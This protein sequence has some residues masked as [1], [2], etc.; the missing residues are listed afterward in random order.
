MDRGN[1]GK[2]GRRPSPGITGIWPISH[3]CFAM[4]HFPPAVISNLQH[5]ALV[6]VSSHSKEAL[7]CLSRTMQCAFFAAGPA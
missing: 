4:S 6:R 3:S 7:E 2:A 5:A 1:F